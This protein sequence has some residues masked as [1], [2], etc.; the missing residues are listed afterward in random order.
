MAYADKTFRHL[1]CV[2]IM[3]DHHQVPPSATKCHQVSPSATKCHQV[4]VSKLRARALSD[5]QCL[6]RGG[7]RLRPARPAALERRHLMA[8]KAVAHRPAEANACSGLTRLTR[9]TR[10]RS[11]A[12]RTRAARIGLR[13]QRTA[14]SG[15]C[16]DVSRAWA[17]GEQREAVEGRARAG[18]GH[19]VE[20]GRA[21]QQPA[22]PRGVAVVRFHS[23]GVGVT[24]E[25]DAARVGR[26]VRRG[27]V[28]HVAVHHLIPMGPMGEGAAQTLSC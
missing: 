16:S 11:G 1:H 26:M 27:G 21:A 17:S 4:L 5:L 15:Q 25:E 2:F 9:L 23:V 13:G 6:S 10:L 14:D 24:V 28:H 20:C 22:E 12:S 19:R 3:A 18:G 7:H 8:P